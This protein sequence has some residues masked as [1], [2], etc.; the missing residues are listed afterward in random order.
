MQ[1]LLGFDWDP[2][3]NARCEA[4]YGFSFLDVIH[5][6]M[7]PDFDYL[8]LGPFDHDGETRYIAVGRMEWA[9]VVA[10]VYTVRGNARRLIWVRPARR[11]ERA[12]FN[13]QNGI[14]P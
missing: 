8:R 2:A 1:P 3:M 6:F 7:D 5:V 11:E 9:A 4:E 14:L 10:V 13:K 12:E